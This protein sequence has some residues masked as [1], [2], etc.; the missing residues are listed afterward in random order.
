MVSD[1]PASAHARAIR[2]HYDS[3]AL[4]YRSFWGDHIHHGLFPRGDESPEEAQVAILE[5]CIAL[6]GVHAGATVLDVGCG[7][8]GASTYLAQTRE[9]RVHG[10]TISPK[11]AQLARE[12]AAR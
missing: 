7:H 2:E 3:L 1:L 4:I 10:L 6:A 9:C 12:N 11:Q 5:H 8:G